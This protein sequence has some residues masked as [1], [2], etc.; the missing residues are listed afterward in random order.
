MK[1]ATTFTEQELKDQ[2][3]TMESAALECSIQ[4]GLNSIPF[5]LASKKNI[6]V[7]YLT[8]P[9][10]EWINGKPSKVYFKKDFR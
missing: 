1:T 6:G 5:I 9:K 3:F 10:S 7:Y 4:E 2:W 8:T